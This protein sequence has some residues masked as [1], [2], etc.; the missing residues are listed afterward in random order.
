MKTTTKRLGSE[1]F[2]VEIR[3]IAETPAELAS[4]WLQ[5]DTSTATIQRDNVADFDGRLPAMV[6]LY[7]PWDAIDCHILGISGEDEGL[8]WVKQQLMPGKVKIA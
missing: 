7:E 6:D 2:P 4:L 8:A 5:L 1:A 3:I